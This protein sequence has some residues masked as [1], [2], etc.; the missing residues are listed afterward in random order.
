MLSLAVADIVTVPLEEI[1]EPLR[2]EDIETE[3][4]VVSVADKVGVG[5]AA[6]GVAVANGTIPED[7]GPISFMV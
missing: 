3:G 7:S 2:G 6:K 1:V 4:T 5:I